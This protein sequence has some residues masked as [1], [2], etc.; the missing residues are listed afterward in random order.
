M[1]TTPPSF[2][3]GPECNIDDGAVVGLHYRDGSA[4]AVVG[5]GAHVRRGTVIYSD[6]IIGCDFTSG[7]NVLVREMS[8]IGDHVVLGTNTVVDGH[9]TISDFVKIESNCYLPTHTSIGHRVFLGP[10][11]TMTNDKYPLKMRGQYQPQGPIVEDGVTIGGGVTILPGVRIGSG[12]FVAAG[13]VV[14]RDVPM[15]CLA[16]GAPARAVPLP[17]E[18]RERN[19]AISWQRFLDP[20]GELRD[21]GAGDAKQP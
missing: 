5:R 4:P 14:T 16:V 9:V 13:A 1:T 2:Q 17:K 18:L 20:D 15:D 21:A 3:L 7:H 8:R 11:V 19:I 10:G 12:S 6:V